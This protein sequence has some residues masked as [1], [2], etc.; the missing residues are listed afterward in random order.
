MLY[1]VRHQDFNKL[2]DIIK[3]NNQD[4]RFQKLPEI[5]KSAT[6]SA[7]PIINSK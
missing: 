1:A 4:P 7:P 6:N 2:Q 3:M 5:R